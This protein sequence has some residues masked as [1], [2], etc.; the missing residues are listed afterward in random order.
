M[1]KDLTTGDAPHLDLDEELAVQDAVLTAIRSGLIRSA[2]DVSDGG[3]LVSLA[4]KAIFSPGLGAD[5]RLESGDNRLDAMLFGEFHSRIVVTVSPDKVAIFEAHVA[6]LAVTA[7]R[8]GE[9]AGDH[10][11]LEIDGE[12]VIDTAV[13]DLERTYNGT[14]PMYMDA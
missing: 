13:V 8:L 14:L 12:R 6:D 9:V 10:L 11:R 1:L 2:H 3:L 7:T 5:L 4:E